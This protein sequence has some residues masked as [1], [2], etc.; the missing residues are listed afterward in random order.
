MDSLLEMHITF[1]HTRSFSYFRC[2][3]CRKACQNRS[4]VKYVI[5]SGYSATSNTVQVAGVKYFPV[6]TSYDRKLLIGIYLHN[7]IFG[8]D[9]LTTAERI[10]IRVLRY[11]Q[12]DLWSLLSLLSSALSMGMG[13]WSIEL[14]TV[15]ILYLKYVEHYLQVLCMP[16]MVGHMGYRACYKNPFQYWVETVKYHR[17]LFW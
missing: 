16:Y 8:P 7:D 3:S 17:K 2:F 5:F 1:M 6:P 12:N 13:N 15:P 11:I 10:T 4:K 9:W 14:V